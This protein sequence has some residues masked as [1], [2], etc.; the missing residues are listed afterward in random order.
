VDDVDDVDD[1]DDVG[2]V[3]D[4][5]AVDPGPD[6]ERG[7]WPVDEVI[8]ALGL[9]VRG[10]T[11]AVPDEVHAHAA[12]RAAALPTTATIADPAPITSS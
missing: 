2:D 4:D 5:G 9:V 8:A 10:V 6:G 3:D 1:A 11:A 12:T 7:T